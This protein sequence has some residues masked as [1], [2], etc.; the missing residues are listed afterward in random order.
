MDSFLSTLPP[1]VHAFL[2]KHPPTDVF[3]LLRELVCFAV[4]YSNDRARIAALTEEL[5]QKGAAE[6][7]EEEAQG[8]SH[9]VPLLSVIK[10]DNVDETATHLT[11]S[12]TS[13][14]A[15]D[16]DEH[17]E[18]KVVN[19]GI[20]WTFP[21]WWG[22]REFQAPEPKEPKPRVVEAKKEEAEIPKREAPMATWIPWEDPPGE[23][24]TKRTMSVRHNVIPDL[25]SFLEKPVAPLEKPVARKLNRKSLVQQTIA[26]NKAARRMSAPVCDSPASTRASPSPP[27]PVPPPTRAVTNTIT[28]EPK[29]TSTVRSASAYRPGQTATVRA[30]AER[31]K[32][33]QQMLEE[34]KKKALQESMR[35]NGR[36]RSNTVSTIDPNAIK[37]E[38][39]KTMPT[40]TVP[41]KA[42]L[43]ITKR[44]AE[45]LTTKRPVEPLT[46]KRSAEPLNTKKPA[47]P[48][49]TRKP[50]QT[51]ITK[52]PTQTPTTRK[53]TRPL[54]K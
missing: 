34:K 39:R 14:T 41:S 44:S 33:Q 7:F 32:Q 45:S 1:Y 50:T 6:H 38:R 11:E 36:L 20:P 31:A 19:N 24:Q 40:G 16:K 43:L 27:R 51:P 28:A 54:R 4:L 29:S 21:E 49:A 25:R 35:I 23:K 48:L 12:T 18:E 53:P 22:H 8:E 42:E 17:Q 5:I 9:Q 15:D 46:T 37:A 26:E 3:N 30:R 2:N 10:E 52:K 47:E 13:T